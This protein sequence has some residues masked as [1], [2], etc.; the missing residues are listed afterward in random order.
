[1]TTDVFF[2]KTIPSVTAFSKQNGRKT[3]GKDFQE[4]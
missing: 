2:K 1:M 3:M 4:A